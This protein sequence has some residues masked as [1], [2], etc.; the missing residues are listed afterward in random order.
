MFKFGEYLTERVSKR[1]GIS[2]SGNKMQRHHDT[3]IKDYLPGGGKE[4]KHGPGTHEFNSDH[5]DPET[6]FKF[7]SGSKVHLVHNEMKGGKNH[8]TVSDDAG[9][10]TTVLASKLARFPH[11]RN[12]EQVENDQIAQIQNAIELHRKN[13]GKNDPNS[14]V[15]IRFGDGNHIEA[16][17]FRK[18]TPDQ[19]KE[20]GY[21]GKGAPKADAY[22]H[23]PDGKPIHFVSLKGTRHQ[24]WGGV[25]HIAN[26][27]AVQRA[28]GEI[29]SKLEQERAAD[30]EFKGAVRHYLDPED[31]HD[32][33]LI[34]KSMY[35][36]KHGREYG[37][38]NVHR[39]IGGDISL[40]PNEENGELNLHSTKSFVNT[41]DRDSQVHKNTSMIFR[42][43]DARNNF[44]TGGRVIVGPTVMRASAKPTRRTAEIEAIK[45]AAQA[46]QPTP[47]NGLRAPSA[48]NGQHR[49]AGATS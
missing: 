38:S 46:P 2:A 10:E 21:D 8:V 39:I 29:K 9:N 37:L 17:G 30:P 22:F 1:P 41:N 36:M 26:H 25:T 35:G 27:P 23:G 15:R 18:V 3:Y 13:T 7:P 24:Q 11:S 45:K 6:G 40:T 48:I 32:K 16:S 42:P 20:L 31:E 34:H 49:I 28:V 19:W 12:P 5:V 44:G 47:P 43:G 14:P 33:D 4:S